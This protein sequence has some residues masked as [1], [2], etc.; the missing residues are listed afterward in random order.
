[1]EAVIKAVQYLLAIDPGTSHMGVALFKDG[2]PYKWDLLQA[3]GR[4]FQRCEALLSALSRFVDGYAVAIVVCEATQGYHGRPAPQL[5][6]LQVELQHF[7]SKRLKAEWFSY[8]PSTVSSWYRSRS[9][10]FKG[11]LLRGLYPQL[12][13]LDFNV[14]DAV[15]VGHVHL[16]KQEELAKVANSSSTMLTCIE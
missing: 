15:A 1:M 2:Q 10:A 13:L 6:T 16:M 8:H 3:K 11:V 5:L 4:V 14:S 12:P 9:K 7:A